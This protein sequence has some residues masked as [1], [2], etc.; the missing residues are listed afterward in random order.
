MLKE[1]INKLIKNPCI[2]KINFP[3]TQPP[4][5]STYI[6]K[7]QWCLLEIQTSSVKYSLLAY[8][9]GRAKFHIH[10]TRCGRREN[11]GVTLYVLLSAIYEDPRIVTDTEWLLKYLLNEFFKIHKSNSDKMEAG[12]QSQRIQYPPNLKKSCEMVLGWRVAE[13]HSVRVLWV[14]LISTLRFRES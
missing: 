10:M 14:N 7:P 13:F 5:P 1:K 3:F 2:I 9:W 12:A 8:N 11:R 4:S 6:T